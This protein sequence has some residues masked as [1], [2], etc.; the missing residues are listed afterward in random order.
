[1]TCLKNITDSNSD[2]LLSYFLLIYYAKSPSLQNSNIIYKYV[3]DFVTC[4]NFTILG[5][6][7]FVKI[8]TSLLIYYYNYSLSW[9]I[10]III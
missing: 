1:M 2:N 8:D 9:T 4:S 6:S 7:I 10:L 3:L 5:W